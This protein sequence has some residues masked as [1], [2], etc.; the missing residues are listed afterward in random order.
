LAC[1]LHAVSITDHDTIEA[2]KTAIPYAA[3]KNFLLGTGVEFSCEYKKK[4]VHILGYDFSLEDPDFLNYCE[5]Q[6]KKRVQRNRGI[7]EKLRRVNVIVTEEELTSDHPNLFTLGRPHIAAV[8]IRKGYVKTPIEA[9]RS[10]LGDKGCCF[11]RGEPFLP[12]E[13]L[14]VIKKAG[15][16]SFLAHPHLYSDAG[17]VRELLCLGFD[18]IECFYGKAS[19]MMEK[20]WLKIAKES[21]LLVSGG[22]DFHGSVKPQVPLGCSYV[23][24]NAFEAIFPGKINSLCERPNAREDLP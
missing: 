20:T 12:K 4:S 21:N 17:F 7:L 16:K 2:Y 8:M 24:E 10:Y 22:S 3:S 23:D 6:Q 15:G 19:Y 13:A 5:R 18:G 1:G 14:A 9:F 11:V